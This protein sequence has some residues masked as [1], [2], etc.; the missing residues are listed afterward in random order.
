MTFDTNA[1]NW[2]VLKYMMLDLYGLDHFEGI[3]TVHEV[4]SYALLSEPACPPDTM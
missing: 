1:G 4:D 2:H 3:C